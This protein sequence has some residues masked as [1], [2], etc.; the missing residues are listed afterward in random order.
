MRLKAIYLLSA[1]K[2]MQAFISVIKQVLNTKL[3]NRIHV[4]K[5]VEVLHKRVQKE[6]LPKD[7]GGNEKSVTELHGKTVSI[8]LWYRVNFSCNVID[9]IIIFQMI[10][11]NN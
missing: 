2:I 6:I 4:V 5:V 9:F 10:G 7:Y 1:T 8:K 11:W 3:S